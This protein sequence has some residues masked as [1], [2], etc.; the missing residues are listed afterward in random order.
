MVRCLNPVGSMPVGIVCGRYG[1]RFEAEKPSLRSA[2][3]A[4]DVHPLDSQTV[5]DEDL[6]ALKSLSAFGMHRAVLTG[7][8]SATVAGFIASQRMGSVW[9]YLL[10]AWVP[11][12]DLR[13]TTET[14]IGMLSA[15]AGSGNAQGVKLLIQ[16][17]AEVTAASAS[18]QQ[19]LHWAVEAGSAEI[20][21]IL[22]DCG[23][24]DIFA[25]NKAGESPMDQAIA[26]DLVDVVKLLKDAVSQ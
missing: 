4:F 26:L 18:G 6:D 12:V 15:A 5:S 25:R 22:V 2:P 24:A 8:V 9:T 19:A 13:A 21:G 20:V 17:G 14:G 10:G 3:Q 23:K 16:A 11:F 1:R 7:S